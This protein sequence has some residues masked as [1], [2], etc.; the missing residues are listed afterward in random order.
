MRR[1]CAH[2]AVGGSFSFAPTDVDQTTPL[3][4]PGN[5]STATYTC[6][7]P[8]RVFDPSAHSVADV[9]AY[10]EKAEDDERERVIAAER[11]GKARV[12]VLGND[13]SG[14]K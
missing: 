5:Y 7:V 13:D 6:K 10:L 11:S 3:Q 12:G 14:E 4:I 8:R 9:N 1:K 2:C